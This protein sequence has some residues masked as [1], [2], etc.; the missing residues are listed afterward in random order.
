MKIEYLH[1]HFLK[2][3][4]VSTDSRKIIRGCLFFA[5]KGERFNGNEYAEQAI[6]MG[7]SYAVVDDPTLQ[8]ND[9]MILV[10]DVLQ[11]LQ[12]LAN[13]HRHQ[14][15]CP[16]L[17]IT[18][19][20]GKTTTKELINVVLSK[21]FKI[22]CT[23]GNLNN[24]IG[25][26]L[27]ILSADLDTEFL[28]VEM[29]AN[30]QNE[31]NYLCDIADIDYGLI[32]NIGKAHLE[33]FGSFE[34]VISA[35]KELYDFIEKKRGTI[36][37]NKNDGLLTSLSN[38]LN[39]IE[40]DDVVHDG[41]SPFASV[42]FKSLVIQ[43]KL[44]GNYNGSNIKA[45]CTIGDFFGVSLNDIKDAIEEYAPQN[46][47]SQFIVTEKQ[48]SLILDAYNANPSSMR[49][50]IQSFNRIS[51][52]KK[53]VILGDMLELGKESI[54]EHQHLIEMIEAKQLDAILI[55]HEFNQCKHGFKQFLN[56]EDCLQWIQENPIAETFILLKGSRG[57]RLEQLRPFL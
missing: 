38:H 36:F 31:I 42:D 34:G 16:V 49:E 7:A 43:S 9:H 45:A 53:I 32:T 37:I 46:N 27:T 20:N 3:T 28:I 23:K 29:G 2:S 57:I 25:V 35:K 5:L 41:E 24:H 51:N 54:T 48:N 18:G 30:H 21:S 6:T 22:C 26:P 44:I 17:G 47:R 56:T 12:Q 39:R 14:L 8:P 52:D 55:G 11:T 4:G 15:T 40:Y 10:D 50:S 33:G 13:Y 19:S 1:D